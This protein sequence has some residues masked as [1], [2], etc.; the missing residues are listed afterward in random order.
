MYGLTAG[1]QSRPSRWAG[2]WC[3]RGLQNSRVAVR[4]RPGPP[5][6]LALPRDY[7][8]P[9]TASGGGQMQFGGTRIALRPDEFTGK[10]YLDSAKIYLE[11]VGHAVPVDDLLDA[12]KRG[13]SPVGGKTP[14]KTLRNAKLDQYPILQSAILERQLHSSSL[15]GSYIGAVFARGCTGATR[16]HLATSRTRG[17]R[18]S[19]SELPTE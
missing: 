9:A 11:R 16:R 13:G 8:T 18:V 2:C 4:F 3:Q 1:V 10:A 12:L 5:L 17:D 15:S 6:N 14:K 7:T 19:R